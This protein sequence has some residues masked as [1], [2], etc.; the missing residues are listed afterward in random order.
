MELM[1][2]GHLNSF[3]ALRKKRGDK[4][5][6]E[7]VRLIVKQVLAA[8]VYLHGML[9][10]HRDI[11]PENIL[12]DDIANPSVVK[13]SDFGLSVKQAAF[14][15]EGFKL[16]CGTEVYKAPEQLQKSVYSKVSHSKTSQLTSG[17]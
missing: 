1:E 7:T 17:R 11:K 6:E 3:M 4:I 13:I 5:S 9:I 14:V 16:D 12:L 2:G 15:Y 8:L 10:A